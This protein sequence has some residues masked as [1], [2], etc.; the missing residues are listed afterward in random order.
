MF[1]V[2]RKVS[3]EVERQPGEHSR[4]LEFKASFV[5]GDHALMCLLCLRCLMRYVS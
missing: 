1:C 4:F 5:V 3:R 2:G